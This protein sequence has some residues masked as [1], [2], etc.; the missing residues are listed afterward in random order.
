MCHGHIVFSCQKQTIPAIVTAMLRGEQF[1]NPRMPNR[2]IFVTELPEFP[3][4]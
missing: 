1:V 2:D 3:R 4:T